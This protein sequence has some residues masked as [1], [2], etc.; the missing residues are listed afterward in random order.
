VVV[1]EATGAYIFKL[2]G[3]KMRA[4]SVV[5][6][7]GR[8]RLRSHRDDDL[9]NLIGLAGNWEVAR[10]LITLAHPYSAADGQRNGLHAYGNE[11]GHP[12]A[13]TVASKESDQLIGGVGIDGVSIW[14]RR[15]TAATR[16]KV[17]IAESAEWSG[18][19]VARPALAI[20]SRLQR[21]ADAGRW[22]C[23][24]RRCAIN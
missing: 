9:G 1:L 15:G 23:T 21:L 4:M 17:T 22:A 2:A 24:V 18:V 12:S 14:Q 20:L 6:E 13:F 19:A 7:T 3:L 8:L 5:I 10:W 16:L 11:A